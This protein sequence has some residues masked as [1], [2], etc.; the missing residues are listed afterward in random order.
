MQAKG[1]KTKQRQAR[2]S[3]SAGEFRRAVITTAALTAMLLLTLFVTANSYLSADRSDT[4]PM[5]VSKIA[6]LMPSEKQ[7]EAAQ[8]VGSIVVEAGS[9][10]RCEE[11]HFDNRTGKMVSANYVDC[12]ARLDRDATP[13]DGTNRERIRQILGAFKK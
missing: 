12:N 4:M 11:R 5:P 10:G 9:K 8:R 2:G 3:L 7:G 13:S 6:P 1:Q